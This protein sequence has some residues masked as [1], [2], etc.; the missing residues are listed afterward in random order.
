MVDF[1]AL[2]D[3]GGVNILGS[4]SR[5]VQEGSMGVERINRVYWRCWLKRYPKFSLKYNSDRI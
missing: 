4:G 5:V 2:W 1:S 3:C